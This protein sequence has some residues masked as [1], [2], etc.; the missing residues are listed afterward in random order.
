MAGIVEGFGKQ[1][2]RII[3]YDGLKE[4]FETRV[5]QDRLTAEQ[6]Q[7]LLRCLVCRHLTGSEI[8]ASFLGDASLLEVRSD[9][10]GGNRIAF[11][12]GSNPHYIAGLFRP[13]ELR[14]EAPAGG[15]PK[16]APKRAAKPR[17]V[18]KVAAPRRAPRGGKR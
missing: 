13:D 6:V 1:V 7:D 11:M 17:R 9:A 16:K 12:A 10:I 8:A 14:K 2:W 18:S 4:I 5:P 3:G 15:R